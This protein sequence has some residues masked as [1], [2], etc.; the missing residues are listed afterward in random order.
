VTSGGAPRAFGAAT[1]TTEQLLLTPLRLEA[2]ITANIHPGHHASAA[3]AARAG[4]TL[5]R[6]RRRAGLAAK[7][8]AG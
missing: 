7:S 8:F 6:G 4:L 3:V 1:M 5:R 2:V